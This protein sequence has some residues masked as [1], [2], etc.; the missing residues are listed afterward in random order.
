MVLKIL[1]QKLIN[2]PIQ[3]DN[4]LTSMDRASL[5]LPPPPL[6]PALFPVLSL[7]SVPVSV[8]RGILRGG[9]ESGG[10]GEFER[11]DKRYEARWKC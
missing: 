2:E 8:L 5:T 11:I 7:I 1:S 9:R 3:Q 4:G 10:D 6:P